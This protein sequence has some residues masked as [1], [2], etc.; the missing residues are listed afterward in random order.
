MVAEL[1]LDVFCSEVTMFKLLSVPHSLF[2]DM[3]SVFNFS[4]MKV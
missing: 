2:K 3:Q 1:C 4:Q